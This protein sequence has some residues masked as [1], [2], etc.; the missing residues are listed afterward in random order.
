MAEESAKQDRYAIQSVDKA[1][2][3]IEQL[4]ELESA[5]L[6]ELAERLGQPKSSL[7]RIILTLEN[8]GFIA[9]SDQDGK[10]CLGFKQLVITK[11][12]L[13]KNSLRAAAI[14]E[15]NKLVE[16][17]GDTVNLGVLSDESALYVEIIEGTHA[18]RMTDRVGSKAPLNA[19]AIGKTLLAFMKP[20]KCERLL[21]TISYPSFTEHTAGNK[22]KLMKRIEE[23]RAKG[24][25]L[26]DQEIV[27]GARCIA[28]PIFDMFGHVAGALSI[29]G[30]L[31]RFPD[32]KIAGISS[33]VK[34][35]AANASR[36]L[37]YVK[38]AD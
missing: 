35:A 7:Y 29:S 10:Y 36:K 14:P 4:A 24:Y 25:A 2:D 26:D 19:T 28:A 5:S 13:E 34:Q 33:E 27:E 1:L 15:M 8:R 23:V 32:E 38:R 31:H 17:F 18:L 37:G 20:D 16:M 11:N 3:V 9:R 12:L 21:E 22:E 30:A 6:I